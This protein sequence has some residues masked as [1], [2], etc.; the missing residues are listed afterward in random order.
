[1][2]PLIGEGARRVKVESDAASGCAALDTTLT[3][4]GTMNLSG[5]QACTMRMR[6]CGA[7]R[8]TAFLLRCVPLRLLLLLLFVAFG[9][10]PGRLRVSGLF[11]GF[12]LRAPDDRARARGCFGCNAL[13]ATCAAR[14]PPTGTARAY[15]V[16]DHQRARR[17]A[18][19]L[20]TRAVGGPSAL[21]GAWGAGAHGSSATTLKTPGPP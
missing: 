8:R 15:G 17:G 14:G 2:P 9:F 7:R 18:A 19:H 5:G 6:P 4:G 13:S 11:S 10:P 3:R 21:A 1:M 20:L 12:T 16:L